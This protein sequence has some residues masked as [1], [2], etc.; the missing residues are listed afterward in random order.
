[1]EGD[2]GTWAFNP[3]DGSVLGVIFAHCPDL[4]EVYLIPM[5]RVFE[6]IQNSGL[7]NNVGLPEYTKFSPTATAM[8]KLW[9]IQ[10]KRLPKAVDLDALATVTD[11]SAKVCESWFLENMSSSR[12]RLN[13]SELEAKKRY[14]SRTISYLDSLQDLETSSSTTEATTLFDSEAS[15]LSRAERESLIMFG[16]AGQSG[17]EA[18]PLD[19]SR[20]FAPYV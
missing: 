15:V 20:H 8:L 10:H 7:G 3:V 6:T 2:C 5:F 14:P 16:K 1:M 9:K 4:D 12:V 19:P 17:G 18:E 11:L 13:D